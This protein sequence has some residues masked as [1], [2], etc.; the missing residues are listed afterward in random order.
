MNGFFAAVMIAVG[1]WD[2]GTNYCPNDGC[3]VSRKVDAYDSYSLHQLSAGGVDTGTELYFRRKTGHANGPFENVWGVS[4]SDDGEFW[5]GAGHVYDVKLPTDRL[6]VQ[7]HAMTGLYSSGKGQDLGGPIEFRSGIEVN[8]EM[9]N[10]WRVGAGWDHRSNLEIYKDNPGLETT[11]L[12]IS[13][14]LR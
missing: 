13:V 14:P 1:V 5:L 10:G 7:L 8:Y 9:D 4:L 12:R 11:F 2:M 6:G 3:L